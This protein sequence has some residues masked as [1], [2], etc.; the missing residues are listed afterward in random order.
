MTEQGETTDDVKK[1]KIEYEDIVIKSGDYTDSSFYNDYLIDLGKTYTNI[2]SITLLKYNLPPL[3]NNITKNNNKFVYII[4]EIEKSIEIKPG[5][6]TIDELLIQLNTDLN[7][8]SIV[9]KKNNYD[10]II[11]KSPDNFSIH[12][13][14]QS[15]NI[16]LGYTKSV[17]DNKSCYR[18]DETHNVISNRKVY[19]FVENILNNQSFVEIDLMC[20]QNDNCDIEY[21]FSNKP[22]RELKDVIIKFKNHR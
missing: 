2:T 6:Y 21:N 7:K 14:E 8:D 15:L 22:I 10:H 18:S 5:N 13:N 4:K 17:Y 12:N 19:M 3:L 11:I 1:E 20:P 16:L 9:M